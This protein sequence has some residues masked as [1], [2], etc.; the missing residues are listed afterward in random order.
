MKVRSL[1]VSAALVLLLAAMAGCDVTND[2]DADGSG[3][4]GNGNNGNGTLDTGNGGNN[5]GN[6]GIGCG[7][8]DYCNVSECALSGDVDCNPAAPCDP[9]S[10]GNNKWDPKCECNYYGGVCEAIAHCS[11]AVCL[12]DTDCTPPDGSLKPACVADA[13]CDSW[14]PK[15]TDPD[16]AGSSKNGSK[17]AKPTCNTKTG[18]CNAKPGT[19]E[20]CPDDTTDCATGDACEGDGWCDGG[21]TKGA[22]PDC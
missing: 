22:D 21:C 6:G 18:F 15:D 8:D 1:A 9:G 3:A 11:S 10:C 13:H 2:A 7:L 20:N 14:C 16:C 12:C 5:G 17:C 4:G 19:T